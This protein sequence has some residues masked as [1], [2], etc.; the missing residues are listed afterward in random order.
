MF[1]RVRNINFNFHKEPTMTIR[2]GN[3]KAVITFNPDYE[4]YTVKFYNDGIYYE[5]ADY[6]TDNKQDAI[7]TA[8]SELVIM[9]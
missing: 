1:A 5:E 9:V 4:E 3:N 7:D 8:N 6:F 2:K